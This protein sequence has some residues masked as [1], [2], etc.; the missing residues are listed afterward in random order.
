[1]VLLAAAP[2]F[3]NGGNETQGARSASMAGASVTLVDAFSTTNNVG[4]L[5]LVDQYHMAVAYE[6]RFFLPEAAMKS[7]TVATPLGDGTLGLVGHT[8]G[9]AGY[10]NN[11]VGLGYAR[12]LADFISLGVQLDYVQ[13]RMGDIY[14]SR[15]ALVGEV[16][17][18]VMPSEHIRLGA[19][20]YNPTRTKLADF[21]NERIPT[22]LRIGGQYIFSEKVSAV[23]EVDKSIDYPV[24][25]KSAVEYSPAKSVFLR[26]G[27]ATAQTS[28][29][30]GCGFLW[31]GFVVDMAASWNQN[32]G[33]S[34]SLSLGYTFG[35]RKK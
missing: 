13:F 1:M 19:H 11:R 32:L 24:N 30:F 31:K 35:N 27:Y 22:S 7:V 8:Y 26:V 16:G 14:G 28:Y 15:S 10:A 29:G 34:S 23:M 3:A 18:L 6:S 12:K 21:A 20:I 2:A 4:A 33:Y 5:G 25:L 17:L 9:Y